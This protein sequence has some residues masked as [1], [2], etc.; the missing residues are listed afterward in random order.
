[1]DKKISIGVIFGGQSSEYDVSCVSAVTIIEALDKNKYDVT[2]IG[3]MLDG[4]WFVYVGDNSRIKD[5]S[6]AS[7]TE[8]L[9]PAIISP[10]KAHHGIMYLDKQNL[11]YEIVRLDCV[12]PAL[13]GENGEDGNMQGLLTLSGIPYVGSR[14]RGAAVTMDKAM[15]KLAV[16]PLKV[17][18]AA[19]IMVNY[20][21]AMEKNPD[22]LINFVSKKMG[23]P[24]FVKPSNAGSSVGVTKAHDRAELLSAL[25]VAS[26]V[27]SRILI[28]EYVRGKEIEVALLERYVNGKK[29]LVAS[30][31][32]EIR[33]AGE[34]YDY[35]AKYVDDRS[36]C[37]VPAQIDESVAKLVREAACRIFRATDCTGLARADFFV[38]GE[39]IVFNEINAIP[40]F[41]EIS[42]FPMLFAADGLALPALVDTLVETALRDAGEF[43]E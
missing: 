22:S 27:D 12:F 40:G 26:K 1:M 24:V 43:S 15:T 38:D 42:M 14:T 21:G 9:R 35:N 28:E 3:I 8:N 4:R 25:T 19:Y 39:K 36:E 30:C 2:K 33:P 23:Y 11:K 20:N 37:I 31:C 16:T 18:Q 7:D 10:C 5:L 41:T 17:N 6:W 34:F 13:H 32:G 29:Q